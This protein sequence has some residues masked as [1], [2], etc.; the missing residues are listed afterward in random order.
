MGFSGR[1]M[2]NSAASGAEIAI[3]ADANSSRA[4]SLRHFPL[5]L[6]EFIE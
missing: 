1:N 4:N 2:R 6:R 3:I 5:I